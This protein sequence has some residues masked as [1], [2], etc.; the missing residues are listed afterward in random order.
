M[1]LTEYNEQETMELFRQ[2]GIR[3]GESSRM[4]KDAR[5]MYAAELKPEA[6]AKIQDIPVSRVYEILGLL[7]K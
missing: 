2:D 7:E 4:E 1:L 6:I 3:K 5:G